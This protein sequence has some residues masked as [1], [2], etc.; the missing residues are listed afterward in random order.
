MYLFVGEE[1]K[2]KVLIKKIKKIIKRNKYKILIDDYK[3]NGDFI[4][5]QGFCI[6]SHKIGS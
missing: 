1:E 4:E 5:S 2:N 6:S 3:I